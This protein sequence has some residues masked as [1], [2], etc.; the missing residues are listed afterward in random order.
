VH[1]ETIRYYERLGLIARPRTSGTYRVY[2]DETVRRLRFV[3]NAQKL[4]FSL[5]E[6]AQLA[7]MATTHAT[8]AE[9]CARMDEKLGDIDQEIQRLTALRDEL[10]RMVDA[11]PR[12][13]P[14]ANC[15]VCDN[16]ILP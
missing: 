14:A 3:R 2:P 4:G 15:K 12:K 6:I 5:K 16:L 13:G 1:V 8:C 9:M 10:A 11:S 7:G